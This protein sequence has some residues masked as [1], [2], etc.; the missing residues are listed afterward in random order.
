MTAWFCRMANQTKEPVKDLYRTDSRGKVHRN[1]DK[2]FVAD[3]DASPR[4]KK[5][6]AKS[7]KSPAPKKTK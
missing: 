2:G 3:A 4:V 5:D 1:Y 7:D 6:G